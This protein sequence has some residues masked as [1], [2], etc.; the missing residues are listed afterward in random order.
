MNPTTT[1]N[2][3]TATT[4][5]DPWKKPTRPAYLDELLRPEYTERLLRLAEGPNW[6][7]I[8]PAR[9]SGSAAW[10]LGLHVLATPTGKFLHPLTFEADP[11]SVWDATYGHLRKTNPDKLYAKAS[12]NGLRLLPNPRSLCMVITGYG[13]DNG[14]PLAVRLLMLSGYSGE[15][16]GSPGL[17]HQIIQ[18]SEE[19][20]ENGDLAHNILGDEDGVQINIEKIVSN[21]SKY[22][23]YV[24]RAG[25]QT[26]P[27]SDLL[28]RLSDDEAAALQ[29]LENVVR[30]MTD[31]EQWERLERLMPA[32]EVATIR[33]AIEG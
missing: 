9:Y 21:E 14:T 16:G 13:A 2:K 20:D 30:R 17:G 3:P 8:V 33:A 31:E 29:P 19:R 5:F 28:G 25:R 18:L 23:R 1:E 4:T 10:M 11:R 12:P 22:P 26:C 32:S 27:I 7:R 15:R 6:M 24:L